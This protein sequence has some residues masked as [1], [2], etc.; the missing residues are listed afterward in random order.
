MPSKYGPEEA[1]VIALLSETENPQEIIPYIGSS[2]AESLAIRLEY[3]AE[4]GANVVYQIRTDPVKWSRAVLQRPLS[5]VKGHRDA[6]TCERIQ[7]E[8]LRLRK[9]PG[10]S[11]QSYVSTTAAEDYLEDVIA[12][13]LGGH[14]WLIPSRK[15]RVHPR[16]ISACNKELILHQAL[17]N[18]P[19][20]REHSILEESELFGLLMEDMSG[21]R[22]SSFTIQF[23]PKWLSHSPNASKSARRCRTCALRAMRGTE[24]MAPVGEVQ[25][26]RNLVGDHP[27]NS[28][29][30]ILQTLRANGI[31]CAESKLR[32]RLPD[33]LQDLTE[34]FYSG[35]GRTILDKLAALQ[36]QLDPLGIVKL[37]AQ[38]GGMSSQQL[39]D[40]Q[41]AMTFRDCSVY[42]RYHWDKGLEGIETRV[43]DLDPKV[44]ESKL[45]EWHDIEMGLIQGGWYDGIEELSQGQAQDTKCSL[46]NPPQ[47]SKRYSERIDELMKDFNA[48]LEV[49]YKSRSSD[50]C[51]DG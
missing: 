28:R 2:P 40:L 42:V 35:K 29:L 48:D 43:G 47:P 26:P 1:P 44:G 5:A 8:V 50:E 22:G 14:E 12:P 13:S 41:L 23:K 33:V 18:R 4:G 11:K 24:G 27:D 49:A 37:R 36:E 51:S 17:G 16:V 6:S 7:D 20:S 32:E 19:D 46:W 39:K 34:Y 9:A 45:D 38:P 30:E 31:P 25:C 15:I 3:L 10:S 21:I